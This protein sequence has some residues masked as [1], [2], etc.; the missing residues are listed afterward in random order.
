M[1]AADAV[2]SQGLKDDIIK[3]LKAGPGFTVVTAA[4]LGQLD[5][6]K[7]LVASGSD[8]NEAGSS[9]STAPSLLLYR[10][11]RPQCICPTLPLNPHPSPAFRF[12][13]IRPQLLMIPLTGAVLESGQDGAH[14]GQ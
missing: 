2:C 4:A 13:L 11:P 7:R 3:K 1:A 12:T 8:V 6:V 9:V 10:G 14:G 5:E